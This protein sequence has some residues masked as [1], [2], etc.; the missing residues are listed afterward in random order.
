MCLLAVSIGGLGHTLFARLQENEKAGTVE[1]LISIGKL[2]AGQIQAFLAERKGDALILSDLLSAGLAHGWLDGKGNDLPEA[3]RR[4]LESALAHNG[5]AGAVLLNANG[6]IRFSQGPHVRLSDAG[7]SLAI[8]AMEGKSAIISD[9]Y[10]GDPAAPEQPMLD[11]FAPVMSKDGARAVGVL[12]LRRKPWVLFALIQ[13]WP[14]A[15]KTA[16]SLLI[17]RDGDHVLFLNELRHRKQTAL[18]LRV[19]L[20]AD[21]NA[22][23]S[24]AI[25][26]AQGQYGSME[27]VDYRG[28]AVLAYTLPVPET[29]WSM[30]VKVDV[31]EVLDQLQHLQTLAIIV[32]V[33]LIALTFALVSGWLK[34]RQHRIDAEAAER[35]R[36]EQRIA[37]VI[38]SAMDAIISVNE[39]QR[40][41]LFNPTAERVFG[42]AAREALGQ[43][44]DRFIPNRFRD[45]HREHIRAFGL[46]GKTARKMGSLG[47]VSGIRADGQE[48]PI[49]ASI[50]Q[51]QIDGHT[52]Y[53]VILRD[54]TERMKIAER[55]AGRARKLRQ[56]SELGLMLSGTP[57][58]I[59]RHVVRMIGELFAVRV[60][61]LSEIVGRDL[62]FKAVYVNGEV[63]LDAGR[64]P[65]D[66]TPCAT[67]EVSNDLRMYDRVAE[68]FP[69]A[70]FLRD[71]KAYSYCGFPSVD[72]AGRVVAVTCLLDDKPHEF[73]EEDQEILRIIGQRIATEVASTRHISERE[74]VEESLRVSAAQLNEAQRIAQIGS[75]ELDL[76]TSTLSW[77]DEAF[78]IFE[79]DPAKFGASYE[80]FLDTVHPD[81]REAVNK[82]YTHSL[83]TREPYEITH[84]LLMADGRIKYVQERCETEYSAEGK[85]LHS[86]G[87]VQDITERKLAEDAIRELNAELEQR[88]LKR[89]AGLQAAKK[90]LESFAYSVSHDLKAPLRSID[91]YSRL[92]LED[93]A[94]KLDDEG[95]GFL[96]NVRQAAAQMHQLIDDLLAYSRL[97]RRAMRTTPVDPR[98][99]AEALLAERAEDVRTLGVAVTLTVPSTS[100]SADREGLSMALRNLLENAL[101]FSQ[102]VPSPAIEIGGRDTGTAYVIFV[103]DNGIGF[104]M[105]F[106]DRIFD[107]FQRLHRAE[108][109]PG[110][111]IG[112][113]IVR[114]AMERMGG[115]AWAESEPGKGAT[116]YLEIPK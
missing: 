8:R 57:E 110:T 61:C 19:P 48:F 101:K 76:A 9:I 86:V 15:S 65:I 82:A 68:R 69:Q 85:P 7:Q 104:D 92:L 62:L 60:V 45:T 84:R 95:C 100:V 23:A 111:G 10:Y 46:I 17:R 51:T 94:D 80:A 13:S 113:A 78:R 88:V 31:E 12:V 38:D 77:S 36:I 33:L 3:L 28:H 20:K 115:R 2:K 63:F 53:T 114:K 59:F 67:V 49:E 1:Q 5:Y 96:R 93:Y 29:P 70:S 71:H 83:Q 47:T 43:P 56:L 97:E 109:Y 37:A 89:T 30:E 105:K 6:T 103:R 55:E 42:C 40:I 72:G 26:A 24:P 4:P 25:R 35:K 22:P 11:I 90:E 75:W 81:D 34:W 50:S 52:L 16:E 64:C 41:V 14:V 18:K 98:A 106:H 91:G 66:V 44:L 99:L 79:I 73:S 32:A 74:R 107:V 87:T 39:D 112:L 116:F 102:G 54:I 58:D 27:S 108:D 21:I